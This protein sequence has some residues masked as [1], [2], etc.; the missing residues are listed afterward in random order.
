MRREILF[1]WLLLATC[2]FAGRSSRAE[3]VAYWNF[4][5]DHSATVGGPGF[6]ATPG[7]GASI[8]G[9]Q[10]KWG[11]GAAHFDKAL[12]Q[13]ALTS[14]S[15]VPA[16]TYSYS[17]WYYLDVDATGPDPDRQFAAINSNNPASEPSLFF[18]I[19][20][21]N[22]SPPGNNDDFL[23]SRVLTDGPGLG[24]S[25][26]LR[27]LPRPTSHKQWVNFIATVD[28]NN[29]TNTTTL[30]A[31]Y[32]GQSM[33]FSS[34]GGSQQITTG[35]PESSTQLVFGADRGLAGRFWNGYIDDVAIYDHVLSPTEIAALQTAPAAAGGPVDPPA[36][37]GHATLWQLPL[38]LHGNSYVMRSPTGKVIVVDGGSD[39][40]G[41]GI[42]GGDGPPV[43]ANYLKSFLQSLGGHVDSWF[44]SHPHSDHVSA[45]TSF[46]ESPD[47]QGLT[48]DN[49]YAQLPSEPWLQI[50]ES[51]NMLPSMQQFKAAAQARG[52]TI[53]QPAR[54]DEFDIDG[55]KFKIL[56]E[57]D[58]TGSVTDPND[59]SMVVKVT[60]PDSSVMF[61]GDLGPT[62]GDLLLNGPYADELQ[63]EY[64][65][66]A[67]HGSHG[68]TKAVYE[69]I[70]PD[71][72]LWPAQAWLY[73]AP[74]DSPHF[75]SYQVRQWMEEL[76]VIENYVMKDGLHEIDL[77]F[78]SDPNTVAGDYNGNGVVDAGDY[79]VWRD[80][81]DTETV[82]GRGA[83]GNGDGMVDDSDFAHWRSRFGNVVGAGSGANSQVPEPMALALALF[84]SLGGLFCRMRRLR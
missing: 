10:S 5:T 81:R 28:Y 75:T 82:P 21:D 31:F 19:D 64:V 72:T 3:L 79:V 22:G 45:L 12:S 49:I 46:L 68:V 30:E 54:G 18:N 63:S 4:D 16:G 14:A 20:G 55:I 70:D 42:N 9:I 84:V 61:L 36:P 47:L 57:I 69:A 56:S 76:G 32:N 25:Y 15:P 13:Y 50:Y 71:Y 23:V 34:Y 27:P 48:I 35:R 11:G 40:G 78:V 80:N 53:I 74:E 38:V 52:K 17:M 43:D 6:N 44:I 59:F 67:H 60:T 83:D 58:E 73:D 33:G 26:L 29:A 39:G 41:T 8:S 1:G 2:L 66:M 24:Q 65:Q 51:A 62:G 37:N 7:N 77:G